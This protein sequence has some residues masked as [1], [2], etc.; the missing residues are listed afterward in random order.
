M[1][2]KALDADQGGDVAFIE[3]VAEALRMV[4]ARS[5]GA[6]WAGERRGVAKLQVS[7][8]CRVRVGGSK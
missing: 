8:L 3:A 5:R 7:S 1:C 6:Q 2:R 4:R